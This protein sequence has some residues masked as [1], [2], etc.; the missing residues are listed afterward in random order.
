MNRFLTNSRSS[1]FISDSL[2]V[3]FL[4]SISGRILYSCISRIALMKGVFWE[5]LLRLAI[6]FILLHLLVAFCHLHFRQAY[7]FIHPC[8][9]GQSLHQVY[10]IYILVFYLLGIHPRCTSDA[11]SFIFLM[12]LAWAVALMVC[13]VKGFCGQPQESIRLQV[14]EHLLSSR[15][16]FHR[17]S[18]S[19]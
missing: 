15:H 16:L 12:A 7:L 1:L 10:L 11:I 5:E 6:L 8:P 2:G 4:Q 18:P 13:P 9:S 17:C 14:F 3:Y 19:C